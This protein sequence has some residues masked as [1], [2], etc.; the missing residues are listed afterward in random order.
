MKRCE[1]CGGPIGPGYPNR[2][3][4][5]AVCREKLPERPCDH[6]GKSFRPFKPRPSSSMNRLGRFC[7]TACS[8]LWASGQDL[9]AKPVDFTCQVCGKVSNGHPN[10]RY[11]SSSCQVQAMR[12]PC[13]HCGKVFVS[14]L[15]TRKERSRFCSPSCRRKWS[16]IQSGGNHTTPTRTELA[17]HSHFPKSILHHQVITGRRTN[18]SRPHHVEVDIA[19]PNERVAVEIDGGIHRIPLKKLKDLEKT[20]TLQNLGWCVLRFSSREVERDLAR[21][22]ASIQSTILKLAAIPA[23]P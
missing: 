9:K 20:D 16:G 11:C 18:Q 13:E 2:K 23:T 21:V 15:S 3:Y 6:C 14:K 5:S 4:C 10:R 7:S 22:V 17:V 1:S 19:F 12:T 8:S